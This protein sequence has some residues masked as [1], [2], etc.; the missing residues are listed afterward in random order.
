MM[1]NCERAV[2]LM[3]LSGCVM[4]IVPSCTFFLAEFSTKNIRGIIPA[5]SNS[6][7]IR[8]SLIGSQFVVVLASSVRRS[9]IM[10]IPFVSS[11]DSSTVPWF[12]FLIKICILYIQVTVIQVDPQSDHD[13]CDFHLHPIQWTNRSS[14]RSA[15]YSIA[16]R[17]RM[18]LFVV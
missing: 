18:T 7:P 9:H 5:C 2:L 16:K 3:R 4:M 11:S 17:N 13:S 14:P 1:H 15:P 6:P 10:S 8:V 12:E